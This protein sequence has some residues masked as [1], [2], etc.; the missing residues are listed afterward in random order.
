[1]PVSI[2]P[3]SSGAAKAIGKVIPELAG[4]MTGS[5]RVYRRSHGEFK[6]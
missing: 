1:V 3:Y 4:R 2:V 6:T 5:G